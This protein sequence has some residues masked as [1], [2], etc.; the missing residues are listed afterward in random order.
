MFGIVSVI[1]VLLPPQYY[2]IRTMSSINIDGKLNESVWQI[3]KKININD[4]SYKT[5]NTVTFRSVWDEKNLYLSFEVKDT[6][7]GACQNLLDHPLLYKDDMVEFLLD[8]YNE[9]DS[10]WGI[11]NLIYHI[12]ILGQKKDDRGSPACVTDAAWN[13]NAKYGITM[14]GTLNNGDDI[15]SGYIIEVAISWEEIKITPKS[16]ITIGF[17][18][19]NGDNGKLYDWAGA[20][21]FRSPYAFGNLILSK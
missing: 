3:S 21:P 19:A 10:C 9:K 4:C 18:F 17:D 8:P 16:G 1:G 15:D 14:N 6:N 13:G 11:N 7:L 5:K 12:N 2:A 20:S